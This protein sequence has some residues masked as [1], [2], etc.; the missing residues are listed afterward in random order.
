MSL[1]ARGQGLSLLLAPAVTWGLF[2]SVNLREAEL[3]LYY[4]SSD[5]LSLYFI[6]PFSSFPIILPERIVHTPCLHFLN[7]NSLLTGVE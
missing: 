5:S 1:R 6:N 2:F 7:L 3:Y 4:K